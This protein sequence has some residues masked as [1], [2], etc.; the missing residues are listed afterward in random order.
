MLTLLTRLN[1]SIICSIG[2]FIGIK[3]F[4]LSIISLNE[5]NGHATP[6]NPLSA[7]Y[8]KQKEPG[9]CPTLFLLLELIE[10]FLRNVAAVGSDLAKDFLVQPGIHAG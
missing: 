8:S 9:K 1:I 2:E 5:L 6:L 7:H 10:Q 3:L 4:R